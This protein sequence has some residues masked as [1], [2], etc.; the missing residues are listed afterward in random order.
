MYKEHPIFQNTTRILKNRINSTR[1]LLVNVSKDD[2]IVPIYI[3]I[4][5]PQWDV[6]LLNVNFNSTNITFQDAINNIVGGLNVILACKFA[7]G[8]NLTPGKTADNRRE[9]SD[10]LL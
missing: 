3:N 5:D 7:T 10:K 2:N 4:S 6:A 8:V 1:R 9:N